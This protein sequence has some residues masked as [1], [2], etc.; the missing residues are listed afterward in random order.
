MQENREEDQC[1]YKCSAKHSEKAGTHDKDNE[2]DREL[3]GNTLWSK[4][5]KPLPEG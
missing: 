5:I 1:R 3:H 2:K 4:T